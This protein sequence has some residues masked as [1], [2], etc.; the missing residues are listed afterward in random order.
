MKV[1]L[2]TQAPCTAGSF[3]TKYLCE[4]LN[5]D[6][7]VSEANPWSISAL[8]NRSFCPLYPPSLPF[9][10][11]EL[12]GSDNLA[13]YSS[14]LDEFFRIARAK[15]FKLIVIRDHLFGEFFLSQYWERGDTPRRPYWVD[16]FISRDIDF[17]AV[18]SVRHPFDS[19]VSLCYSF[20]KIASSTSLELYSQSYLQAVA[21]Y[22]V[23]CSSELLS[24]ESLADVQSSHPLIDDLVVWASQGRSK[25]LQF[26]HNQRW[27]SSGASGRSLPKPT[28]MQ[29]RRHST[30]LR[31]QVLKSDSFPELCVKLGYV[32][33]VFEYK[34][35]AKVIK[36]Y[37]ADFELLCRAL[38][39]V[40]RLLKKFGLDA[41]SRQP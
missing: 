36:S 1:L 26:S 17:R 37:L 27:N 21:S 32:Y 18:F 31:K 6:C 11:G 20:P 30:N 14:A 39:G 16:Y 28:K 22:D 19:Y 5:P 13:I 10:N 29:C 41:P 15:S 38:P 2:I 8:T 3:I 25:S 40:S 33:D 4:Q 7:L 23:G 34:C 24:I 9:V 35:L 12:D